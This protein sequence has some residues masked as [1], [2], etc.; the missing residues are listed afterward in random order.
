MVVGNQGPLCWEKLAEENE[1]EF[2]LDESFKKGDKIIIYRSGNHRD[3][4]YI[5]EVKKDSEPSYGQ[6]KTIFH[7]KISIENTLKLSE[8][9]KDMEIKNW[10]SK[11]IKGFYKIPFTQ[12]NKIVE[13]ISIN[14]PE[15][16]ENHRPNVVLVLT[17]WFSI[18]L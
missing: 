17:Q 12:W 2:T 18:K 7:E 14:N 11:F 4:P 5:F 10:R 16:F 15:L 8:M 6:Y 3:L 13:L 1:L 9:K